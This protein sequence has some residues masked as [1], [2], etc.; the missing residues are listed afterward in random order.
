M[1]RKHHLHLHIIFIHEKN[2]IYTYLFLI[3]LITL[4]TS[5][6]LNDAFILKRLFLN[7]NGRD[8]CIFAPSWFLPTGFALTFRAC[9]VLPLLFPSRSLECPLTVWPKL[10]KFITN[11]YEL[12]KMQIRYQNVQ[13]NITFMCISFAFRTKAPFKL[14]EVINVINIIKNK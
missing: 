14:P 8:N 6:S 3:M 12:R 1:L 9:S 5:G 7:E 10:W 2:I 4:I 11:S 13:I